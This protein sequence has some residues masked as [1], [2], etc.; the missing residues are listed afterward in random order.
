MCFVVVRVRWQTLAAGNAVCVDGL[1]GL[2]FD[3]QADLVHKALRNL[4]RVLRKLLKQL[5]L[6]HRAHHALVR[7]VLG[8]R[9]HS[10]VPR[11]PRKLLLLHH[12]L[13]HHLLRHQRPLLLAQL[14]EL[15]LLHI[16]RYSQPRHLGPAPIPR[17]ITRRCCCC[18]CC[19]GKQRVFWERRVVGLRQ[20]KE[21]VLWAVFH[22]AR[23]LYAACGA[24][25]V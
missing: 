1:D 7:R 3:G 8:P 24:I 19:C 25:S 2:L 14:L 10:L 11:R 15:L 9:H 17:G 12:V 18:C 13:F 23:R 5:A 22:P 6:L 16:Q 20:L 4:R 21:Q